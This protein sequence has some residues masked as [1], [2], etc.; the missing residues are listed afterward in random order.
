M[1]ATAA[2]GMAGA[3][4]M[5][6]W[7]GQCSTAGRGAVASGPTV[8]VVLRAQTGP[9]AGGGVPAGPEAAAADAAGDLHRAPFGAGIGRPQSQRRLSPSR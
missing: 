1:S 6:V 8:V 9:I 5:V 2:A 7:P 3:R 4:G